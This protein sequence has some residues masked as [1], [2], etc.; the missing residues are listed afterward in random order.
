[1]KTSLSLREAW[2]NYYRK[3]FF[4]LLV[5][6]IV[7]SIASYFIFRSFVTS[8]QIEEILTQIGDMFESRGLTFDTSAFDTMIALFV[9]NTRVALLA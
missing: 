4:R 9:N 5:I 6:F 1:M 2:S 3:D 8:E 7:T